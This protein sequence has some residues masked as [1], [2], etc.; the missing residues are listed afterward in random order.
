M[1]KPAPQATP[2]TDSECTEAMMRYVL[3]SWNDERE[4]LGALA[5]A[6]ERGLT[7]AD[8]SDPQDGD[9]IHAWRLSQVLS[10]LLSDVSSFSV[11]KKM[12]LSESR[13]VSPC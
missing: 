10:G 7:P 2:R 13:E 6:L 12:A 1:A 9:N 4:Q 3:E 11:L 5:M 8:P